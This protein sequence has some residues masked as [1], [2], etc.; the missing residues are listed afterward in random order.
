[1]IVKG[2]SSICL[3]CFLVFIFNCPVLSENIDINPCV[4]SLG[5]DGN[6]CGGWALDGEFDCFIEKH[7]MLRTIKVI[8]NKSFEFRSTIEFD[9]P[10]DFS[11]PNYEIDSAILFL[12][13]M[14]SYGNTYYDRLVVH[15]HTENCEIEL[16]DFEY[17]D[18]Y[19]AIAFVELETGGDDYYVDITSYVKSLAGSTNNI[20]FILTTNGAGGMDVRIANENGVNPQLQLTYTIKKPSIIPALSPLLLQ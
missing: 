12:P 4:T 10:S 13:N 1:M 3:S 7:T 14:N 17:R 6:E 8:S 15:G 2:I 9:L 16:T 11:N 19:D 18:F 20:G 5:S